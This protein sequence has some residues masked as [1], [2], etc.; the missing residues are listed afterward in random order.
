MSK[1]ANLTFQELEDILEDEVAAEY[2]MRRN[3]TKQEVNN[4]E[5]DKLPS[6][7][8]F[9]DLPSSFSTSHYMDWLSFASHR[10]YRNIGSNLKERIK[11]LPDFTNKIELDGELKSTRIKIEPNYLKYFYEVHKGIGGTY[12]QSVHILLMEIHNNPSVYIDALLK[13]KENG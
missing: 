1:Y 5:N 11:E 9:V 2:H 3:K 13:D 10:V 7:V 8:C 12:K 4:N 6:Q